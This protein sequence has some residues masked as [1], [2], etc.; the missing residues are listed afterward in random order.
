[1]SEKP[2]VDQCFIQAFVQALPVFEF[3][4]KNLHHCSISVVH[5]VS[6]GVM[7]LLQSLGKPIVDFLQLHSHTG[8]EIGS[9]K[10]EIVN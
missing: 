4:C 3:P 2:F 9:N 6:L 5:D 7:Y 8:S 10:S 1:M